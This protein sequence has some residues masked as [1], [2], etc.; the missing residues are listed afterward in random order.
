[1]LSSPIAPILLGWLIWRTERGARLKKSSLF[2]AGCAIPFLPL[3]RLAIQGPRQVF[4]D[5]V[6]YHL[7]YRGLAF[8]VPGWDLWVLELGMLSTQSLILVGLAVLCLSE[9]KGLSG[10]QRAERYLAA[11]L[12][13]GLALLAARAHPTFEQY[14]VLLTPF[15][16]ILAAFGFCSIGSRLWPNRLAWVSAGLVAL[17]CLNAYGQYTWLYDYWPQIENVGRAINQV[18]AQSGDAYLYDPLYFASRRLPP[19]GLENGFGSFLPLAPDLQ[20]LL[21]IV[22][23]RQI[24]SR[25]AEGGFAVA[26]LKAEDGRVQS[27]HLRRTYS[28]CKQMTCFNEPVY[29]FWNPVSK[30]Q[31]SEPYKAASEVSCLP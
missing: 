30:S 18:S 3:A 10:R 15:L 8:P 27:L 28:R 6:Q 20:A 23:V 1:M 26:V 5:V 4:F 29:L 17:F 25:L 7:F 14:F 13:G 9:A 22:P 12:V 2:L 19:P 11:A 24:E 16:A 21:H 31:L